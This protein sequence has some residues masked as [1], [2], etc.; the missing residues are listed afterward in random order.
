MI[1]RLIVGV[2]MFVTGL[3]LGFWSDRIWRRLTAPAAPPDRCFLCGRGRGAHVNPAI[4]GHEY[5]PRNC[6]LCALPREAQIHR[7]GGAEHWHDFYAPLR[8]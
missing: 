3:A 4:D 2:A 7:P 8:R 5:S 1:V 6:E